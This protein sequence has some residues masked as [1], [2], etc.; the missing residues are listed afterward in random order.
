MISLQENETIRH[1]LEM[2]EYYLV[3][4]NLL[5]DISYDSIF[6]LEQELI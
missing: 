1:Q 3:A 6:Y 2:I 5:V 4:A